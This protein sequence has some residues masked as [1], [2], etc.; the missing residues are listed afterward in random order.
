MKA[1]MVIKVWI[2]QHYVTAHVLDL[3]LTAIENSLASPV[4][5]GIESCQVSVYVPYTPNLV[6]LSNQYIIWKCVCQINT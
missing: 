6:C 5:C 4:D 2:L 3:V 1:R